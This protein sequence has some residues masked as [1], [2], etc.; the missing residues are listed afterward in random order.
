M[1]GA[2]VTGIS[3]V[4]VEKQKSKGELKLETK[5]FEESQKI[6]RQKL[7]SDLVKLALQSSGVNGAKTLGFMVQTHLIEDPEIRAG[8]TRYLASSSPVPILHEH[9]SLQD[10][11]LDA[12]KDTLTLKAPHGGP[13]ASVNTE[14]VV[15]LQTAIRTPTGTDP[16]YIRDESEIKSP[17]A[18][19]SPNGE[20]LF[21][22][23]KQKAAIYFPQPDTILGE[24]RLRPPIRISPPNGISQIW[25]SE[26][27][28]AIGVTGTDN[29]QVTYDLDGNEIKQ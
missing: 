29:K 4:V 6:E 10:F 27:R 17:N 5:K 21:V 3:N 24:Q 26:D 8:I 22:Y 14:G 23:N 2:L 16:G 28:K 13:L 19:F 15:K 9:G 20:A 25:L 1:L 11:P 7:D 18:Y 12:A